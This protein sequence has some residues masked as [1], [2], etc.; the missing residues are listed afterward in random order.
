LHY[1]LFLG[2]FNR[3]KDGNASAGVN[4]HEFEYTSIKTEDFMTFH[5]YINTP[6][7]HRLS[8]PGLVGPVE[9]ILTI[10][11]LVQTDYFAF[12]GHPHSLQGG[13]M[14]NKVVTTMARIFKELGIPALR[15]NFRGVGESAGE[16]DAG[17]GESE[18]LLALVRM[19]QAEEMAEKPIFAG[20]S[21]G[22]Y[23]TYRAAAQCESA[24][25]ISIAPPV[26]HYDYRQ[27]QPS[28]WIMVQGDADEVVPAIEVIAFACELS[29]KVILLEFHDTGHFFHGKL[30]ELKT[31]LGSAIEIALHL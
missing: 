7:E 1:R 22:S 20:F 30:L 13:S 28:P 5:Q 2:L 11:S 18:D 10:P 17:I 24:L 21:F 15:F 14:S 6:G 9:A 19:V 8:L 12:L 29:S 27:W 25:L 31:R 3:L 23:V 16:Y 26:H 4:V